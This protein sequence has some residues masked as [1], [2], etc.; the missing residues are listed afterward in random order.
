M[1]III[2]LTKKEY[3][4]LDYYNLNREIE[5][6]LKKEIKQSLSV[7]HHSGRRDVNTFHT[8]ISIHVSNE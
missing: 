5:K 4:K 6:I 3:S 2:E 8:N 1:Q 7:Y